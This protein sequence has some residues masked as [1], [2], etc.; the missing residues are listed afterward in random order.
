MLCD[1][2]SLTSPPP[3]F[4]N[5]LCSNDNLQTN[6]VIKMDAD[7]CGVALWGD[8]DD[9]P[10]AVVLRAGSSDAVFSYVTPGSMFAVD[11]VEQQ[12]QLYFS[13]GGKHTPANVMGEGGDAYTWV[14]A[15]A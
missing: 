5:L 12:G 11:L 15:S 14:I 4:P 7:Y 8:R 6:P 1:L 3:L 10:T 2:P 13:V 9:V